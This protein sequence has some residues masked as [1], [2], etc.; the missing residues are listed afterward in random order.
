M[1]TYLLITIVENRDEEV[2]RVSTNSIETRL[3]DLLRAYAG[4]R[5][6]AVDN[7][8]RVA[9]LV[10]VLQNRLVDERHAADDVPPVGGERALVVAACGLI[11]IVS[12]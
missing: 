2:V 11:V 3:R 6:L 5:F 8:H 1:G 4:V 12:P 10:S 7:Q 9:D